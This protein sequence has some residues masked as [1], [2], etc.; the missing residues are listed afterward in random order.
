MNLLAALRASRSGS[1]AAEMAIIAPLLLV[2]LFGS[3]EL[4]NYF[5]NEHKLL[6]G[7]RDGA[8][9]AARQQF[10]NYAACT[11]SVPTSGTPGSVY[12]NT[13]LIVRKGKLSTTENDLL[14]NW[15][16][17]TASC[18]GNPAGGCFEVTMSCLPDLDDITTGNTL[19]LGG[20]YTNSAGA[21]TVVVNVRLPYYSVL[22]TTLGL[23]SLGIYLNARQSAAVA[24]L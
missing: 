16:G 18:A 17:V 11:G 4:G 19:S 21:P 1:A 7:V 24:G 5:Y 22:G 20:I 13:K 15:G 2:I 10:S 9:Y 12:E 23:D 3:V 14:A 8:R 6:K